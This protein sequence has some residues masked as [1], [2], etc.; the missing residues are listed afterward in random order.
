[1]A[2]RRR[3]GTWAPPIFEKKV[4]VEVVHWWEDSHDLRRRRLKKKRGSGAFFFLVF[5][6][7]R[8]PARWKQIADIRAEEPILYGPYAGRQ[9]PGDRDDDGDGGGGDAAAKDWAASQLPDIFAG[10][11]DDAHALTH[12]AA[13]LLRSLGGGRWET[14]ETVRD[15]AS[16]DAHAAAARTLAAAPDLHASLLLVGARARPAMPCAGEA[17]LLVVLAGRVDETRA[18]ATTHGPG[19]C[20]PFRQGPDVALRAARGGPALCAL[21]RV[22]ADN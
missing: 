10:A 19:A 5:A 11:T 4:E 2:H 12:R 13:A 3:E 8:R 17:G 22:P 14:H 18:R 9:T 6:C 7:G 21:L 15:A 20:L 1:M 16:D